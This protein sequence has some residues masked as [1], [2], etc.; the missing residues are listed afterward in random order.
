MASPSRSRPTTAGNDRH[1]AER[2]PGAPPRTSTDV[3]A[4]VRE[5][6]Q[7]PPDWH[8]AGMITA[9]ALRS[10]ARHAER[11][12]E[13]SAET[14]SGRSTLLISHLSRDHTVFSVDAGGSISRVRESPLLR[15]ETVRF[16]EGPSQLTLPDHHFD[17]PLDLV[18]LDGLHSYP[19]PDIDYFHLYPHLAEGGLLIVDDIHI[20]MIRNLYRFLKDDAM[21]SLVEVAAHTAFFRRTDAPAFDR[22]GGDWFDQGY[23]ARNFPLI[24]RMKQR[25]PPGLRQRIKRL[26]GRA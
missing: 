19:G 17:G 11:G 12:V 18:L 20:P 24:E 14:G 6:E 7:L 5:L 23:N 22:T 16:V 10:I 25:I 8:G 2:P 4:L 13:R 1:P 21:F 15:R 3:W 9:A 26:I